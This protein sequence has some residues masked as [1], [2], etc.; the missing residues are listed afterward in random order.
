MAATNWPGTFLRRG[1]RGRQGCSTQLPANRNACAPVHCGGNNVKSVDHRAPAALHRGRGG[2]AGKAGGRRRLAWQR[3]A[4]LAS[5][6]SAGLQ[7]SAQ[8]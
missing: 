8:C 1:V 6:L 3:P 2:K 7:R 5:R 4:R